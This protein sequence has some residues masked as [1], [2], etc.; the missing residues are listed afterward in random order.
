MKNL[1]IT[2]LLTL[3]ALTSNVQARNYKVGE[4]TINHPYARST[5]PSAPVAGGFMTITNHGDTTDRLVGGSSPFADTVEIHEMV[6]VDG[7]MK[8]HQI[9]G[10]LE[11]PAGQTVVLKPGSYHVMFI[12]LKKQ[13]KPGEHHKGVLKFEKA[14]DIEI[15]YA[16][17][18]INKMMNHATT[19]GMNHNTHKKIAPHE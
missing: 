17:K 10:G 3:A 4:L 13:L 6:M 7:I 9:E 14:G 2:V 1:V 8:M 18:D 15:E 16:V 11:I 19:G 12:G 5:P